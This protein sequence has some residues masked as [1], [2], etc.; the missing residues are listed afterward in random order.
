V[1]VGSEVKQMLGDDDAAIGSCTA[2]GEVTEAE[3]DNRLELRMVW[4]SASPYF[5]SSLPEILSDQ[6][7][8]SFDIDDIPWHYWISLDI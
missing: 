8:R 7:P 3:A 6:P 2:G 4:G 5:Y 1:L